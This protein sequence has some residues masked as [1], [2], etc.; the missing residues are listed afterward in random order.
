MISQQSLDI[1]FDDHK[2]HLRLISPTFESDKLPVMMVHGAIEDGRIFYTTSGK[3]LA[4]ELAR[5]GHPTYV[6]DLR[7]RGRSLPV[8]KDD[9][10]HGQ[11]E[12]ITQ[13][14][15]NI[16]RY[17]VDK[18]QKRVHWMAHSWGGVLLASTLIRF[19][20]LSDEVASQVFFG[21]KRSIRSWSMERLLKVEI[22]WKNVAVAI[23]KF[24]GYLPAKEMK[25]GSDNETYLS[26]TES[27][28][29]VKNKPWLDIR[30]GFNYQQQ[31]E[32]VTWP[33]SW[34]IAAANDFALGNPSDVK[35]FAAELGL[36]NITI[37]SKQNG[38]LVD[39]DHINMLVHP[40]ARDD[41][42]PEVIDFLFQAEA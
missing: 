21:S 9:P 28:A 18:H 35:D 7:G 3:G 34:F 17:I 19:P 2:I 29:W 36:S 5:A 11:F 23:A 16:H 1:D 32:N 42:F 31:A 4:C 12:S 39:Y 26:L 30:D 10:K 20:W 13:T 8:I 22:F 33:V 40:K 38:N 14:L 6:V 25:M 15:P 27:V 24:K 37:L 41:H